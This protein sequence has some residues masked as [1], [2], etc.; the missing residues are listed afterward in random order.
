VGAYNELHVRD[1][2]GREIAIQFKYGMRRLYVYHVGDRIE[3]H[4][5][6]LDCVCEIPGISGGRQE[7]DRYFAIKMNGDLIES[8]RE[9]GEEEYERLQGRW[10]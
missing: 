6:P 9:I 7:H 8:Y 3:P 10:P 2:E 4:D 5:E 1:E